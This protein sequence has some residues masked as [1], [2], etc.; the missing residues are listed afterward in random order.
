MR[1]QCIFVC[2]VCDRPLHENTRSFVCCRGHRFDRA[3][4]GYVN[5]Y[6][7]A[8]HGDTRAMLLAR[9][10]FL[11]RGVFRPISAAINERVVEHLYCLRAAN[12]LQGDEAIVDAG[13]G[14]GYYLAQLA[15]HLRETGT[16][17]RM[18]LVGLDASKAAARLTAS[19][20][21]GHVCAVVDIAHG[22]HIRRGGAA[23]LLSI[24]APRNPGAFAHAL[25]P[26]GVC[27]VVIPRPDHMRELRGLVPLLDIPPSKRARVVEQFHPHFTP[28]RWLDIDYTVRLDAAAVRAW[29]Q[30]GPNA[31]HLTSEQVSAIRFTGTIAA[32]VECTVIA[33]HRVEQ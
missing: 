12:R 9:R 18:T 32:K 31:W 2:P 26:G 24:F 15:E 5:L 8:R 30:M 33:L 27:L 28:E 14:E 11:E 16:F 10:A 17:D 19:R 25:M 29:V 4:S 7:T 20:L 22:L 3:R 1:E 13:C 23:V 21:P 6:Q